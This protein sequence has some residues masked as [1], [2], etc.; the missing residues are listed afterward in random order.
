MTY[1]L[2]IICSEEVIRA[3]RCSNDSPINSGSSLISTLYLNIIIVMTA[4]LSVS[5][6]LKRKMSNSLPRQSLSVLVP[7]PYTRTS[8]YNEIMMHDQVS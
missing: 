7:S 6:N 4:M 3:S 2:V 8:T 1:V 5:K